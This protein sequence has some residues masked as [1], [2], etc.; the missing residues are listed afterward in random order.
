MSQSAVVIKA[1]QFGIIVV[2]SP[3]PEFS[4]LKKLR[5]YDCDEL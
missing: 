1:N 2:M 4:E 3:E 5:C